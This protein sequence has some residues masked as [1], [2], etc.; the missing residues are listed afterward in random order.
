MRSA[1]CF[2][3]LLC[4]C[5]SHLVALDPS[6]P[7]QKY[8]MEHWGSQNGLPS[9]SVTSIIQTPD[10]YLWLG[11]SRGIVRFDG[12]KFEMIEDG[13][14]ERNTG[15]RKYA[16]FVDREGHLWIGSSG[17][18]VKR[19][20]GQMRKYPLEGGL[21]KDKIVDLL[22]DMNGNFWVLTGSAIFNGL[23]D[24]NFEVISFQN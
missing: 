7:F 2:F 19:E 8:L 17:C 3:L 4:I 10:G 24:S 1:F 23:R 11:T 20:D 9:D 22:E 15:E 13:I 5:T 6:T 12:V 16:L 14:H 18:V 21:P